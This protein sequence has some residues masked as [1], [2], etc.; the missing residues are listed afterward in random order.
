MASIVFPMASLMALILGFLL[1]F[2]HGSA[3][4]LLSFLSSFSILEYFH[5]DIND[6]LDQQSPPL[7]SMAKECSRTPP[8][9]LLPLSNC[10]CSLWIVD[11]H[12]YVTPPIIVLFF[13]LKIKGLMPYHQ[14]AHYR[15]SMSQRTTS[16]WLQQ[17]LKMLH[18]DASKHIAN[19]H[20][21]MIKSRIL[22]FN[23]YSVVS[24]VRIKESL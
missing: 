18:F 15:F 5:I 8:V 11:L 16:S 2:L 13:L 7:T 1:L 21:P 3:L 6:N 23:P 14:L 9:E 20:I 19:R 4:L 22:C 24:T 12:G 10:F 17:C